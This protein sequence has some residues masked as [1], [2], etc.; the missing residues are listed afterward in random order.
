MR[1]LQCVIP[2]G[3][4]LGALD[5]T[6][7]ISGAQVCLNNLGFYCGPENGELNDDTRDALSAFQDKHKLDVTGDFDQPTLDRLQS[8]HQGR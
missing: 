8:M 3:L 1:Q 6:S 4:V 5:P 7:E 2:S